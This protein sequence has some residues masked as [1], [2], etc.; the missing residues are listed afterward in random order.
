MVRRSLGILTNSYSHM[1]L[2][3]YYDI[4]FLCV[5][6]TGDVLQ[7]QTRKYSF[8]VKIR[9]GVNTWPCYISENAECS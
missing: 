1:L 9:Y 4:S 5:N 2:V 6:V 7:N 8:A 3:E